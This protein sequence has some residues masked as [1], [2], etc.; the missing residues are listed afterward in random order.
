MAQEYRVF[1]CFLHLFTL[2]YVYGLEDFFMAQAPLALPFP[3][4][5]LWTIPLFVIFFAGHPASG[6]Y[7]SDKGLK[8]AKRVPKKSQKRS[9]KFLEQ[10]LNTDL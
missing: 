9:L 4:E 2:F 10:N 7:I 1:K 6:Y 8:D 5:F 3:Y